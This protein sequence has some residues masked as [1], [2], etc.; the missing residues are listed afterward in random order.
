MSTT[1]EWV[2]SVEHPGY[3]TKV[4]QHGNCTIRLLRPE[5]DKVERAKREKHVTAVAE[6]TL[7]DYYRRKELT[8]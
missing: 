4:I 5:L 1:D 3:K 6:Q 7:A 2:D 8:T